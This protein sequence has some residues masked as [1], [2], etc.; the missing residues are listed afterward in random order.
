MNMNCCLIKKLIL[1]QF[2]LNYQAGEANKNICSVKVKE[3]L[4]TY[5]PRN[6]AQVARTSSIEEE[7]VENCEFHDRRG[8]FGELHLEIIRRAHSSVVRKIHDFGKSM[9]DCRFVPHLIKIL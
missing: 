1:Y 4:I 9:Q 6:F 3:L 8:Y 5:G 7:Q 2:E